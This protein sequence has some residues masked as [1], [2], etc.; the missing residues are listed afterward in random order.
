MI[1]EED[2]AQRER[3]YLLEQA[4]IRA[5]A[6]EATQEDFDIIRFECGKP[7]HSLNKQILDDVF[8]DFNSIFSGRN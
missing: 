5:E 8:A 4:L 6:G 3:E 2:F 1:D 7:R